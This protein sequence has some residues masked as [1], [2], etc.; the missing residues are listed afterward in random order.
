MSQNT[1]P[2]SAYRLTID[3]QDITGR[4]RPILSSLSIS[5][6]QRGE[7][8]ELEIRLD[9][10]D[11]KIEIPR[12]GVVCRVAIGWEGQALVDK[13]AFVVDETGHEG[14]PDTVVIRARSVDLT[15]Q[16]RNR[17]NRSW[18][19]TT[20]GAVIRD[21]AASQGL[22]PRISADLA[23][24]PVAHLDQVGESDVNLMTRLAK[25]HDATA[26][27]KGR[28][29]IFLRIG[30]GTTA[31]GAALPGF[32]IERSNCGRHNVTF[33]DRDRF[34]GVHAEWHDKASGTR[35]K[36]Q[37]G[38]GKNSKGLRRVYHSESEARQHADAEYRKHQRGEARMSVTLS[39]GDAN[40]SAEMIG[41]ARGWRPEIDSIRWLAASVNHTLTGSGGFE[42]TLE[43]EKAP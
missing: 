5:D 34:S 23:Q 42:T 37:V 26:T 2:R 10:T 24:I 28:A 22:Q 17:R 35:K 41:R 18:H 29:L 4:V 3:G 31:S 27:V 32:T 33:A 13:G 15:N 1:Q 6:R 25:Q 40:L 19:Q 11:G 14:P 12:K 36:V 21:L 20:L 43:L 38:D 7:A 30:K 8:D 39:R 16:A 9:D